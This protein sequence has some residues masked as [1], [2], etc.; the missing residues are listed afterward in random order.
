MTSNAE[1]Q[2]FNQLR[3]HS[4]STLRS[5]GIRNFDHEDSYLLLCSNK[6]LLK[7]EGWSQGDNWPL[8]TLIPVL[9]NL[10]RTGEK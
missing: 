6:G 4:R 7:L 2:V 10:Q 9:L 8:C 1:Y 3:H 5:Y